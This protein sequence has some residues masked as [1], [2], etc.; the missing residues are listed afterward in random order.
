MSNDNG[1]APKQPRKS[2]KPR[3]AKTGMVCDRVEF[4]PKNRAVHLHKAGNK[5]Q[6]LKSGTG[7]CSPWVSKNEAEELFSQQ[8]NS[9]QNQ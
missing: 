2:R 8:I 1:L 4:D 5:Y 6:V 7:Y 9:S 3:V